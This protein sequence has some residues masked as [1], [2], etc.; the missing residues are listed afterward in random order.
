[1]FSLGLFFFSLQFS[2]RLTR[3]IQDFWL[4]RPDFPTLSFFFGY[5]NSCKT[6]L[7]LALHLA[8]QPKKEDIYHPPVLFLVSLFSP[9][10]LFRPTIFPP[11]L[12]LVLTTLWAFFP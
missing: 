3:S 8:C 10:C 2:E 9:R 7:V 4:W 1:L 12:C 6:L 11:Y 5:Y